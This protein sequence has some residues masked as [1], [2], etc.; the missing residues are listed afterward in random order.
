M[1]GIFG[2]ISKDQVNKKDLKNLAILSRER[3][4]DSSGYL[5]Y[6]TEYKLKRFDTDLKNSVDKVLKKNPVLLL[7]IAGLLQI[8]HMII[9]QF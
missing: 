3:G 7:V 8:Q 4:R 2:I 1:C 9:N 5:L 6:D